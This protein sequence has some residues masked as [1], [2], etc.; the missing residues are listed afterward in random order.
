[1]PLAPCI[2]TQVVRK[3]LNRPLTLA[4]KVGDAESPCDGGRRG[5][6]NMRRGGR[7]RP[8]AASLGPERTLQPTRASQGRRR[9]ST[10]ARRPQPQAAAG[11]SAA[12]RQRCERCPPPAPFPPPPN[13]PLP[14]PLLQ[15]VY[16]HLDDP[17]NQEIERGVS[18]L[19]LRPGEPRAPRAGAPGGAEGEPRG[20][21]PGRAQAARR[22]RGGVWRGAVRGGCAALAGLG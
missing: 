3:R 18:Y 14:F 21:R 2:P 4:E 13:P 19:K 8:L 6:R 10:R 22:A 9:G 12:A 11:A 17:A 5:Q 16:G 7:T 20:S 15:V 1:M